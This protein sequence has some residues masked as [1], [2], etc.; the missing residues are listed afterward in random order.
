MPNATSLERTKIPATLRWV[1]VLLALSAFINYIDR[2]NLGIAGPILKAELSVSGSQLGI[3]FSAFFLTYAFLQPVVGWLV[4]RF[5]VNW[6][7]AFGFLLWSL[8]TALTGLAH[9]FGVLLSLR[10]LLGVGESVAYPSYSKIIATRL[11]EEHRGFANACVTGGQTLGPAFG[12]FAGGMLMARFG[13]RPFFIGLGV[14]AMIWLIP[15]IALIPRG[16]EV[17]S[18]TTGVP[19]LLE[20]LVLR[21]AW[22][23]CLGLFCSNY[24]NYFLITW[25]PSYLVRERQFSLEKAASVIAIGYLLA[26]G[27]A[28]LAGWLSDLWI[29]SGGTPTRVRKT[30]VAGSIAISGVCLGLSATGSAAFCALMVVGGIVFWAVSGSNLWAITQTLAGAKAAGRWTGFQNFVGN[31]AGIVVPA[32]TGFTLDRTGHF[33]WALAIL[34]GLALFGA[35]C[36]VFLIGRVEPVVWRKKEQALATAQWRWTLGEGRNQ[37]KL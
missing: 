26:S 4:D 5:N 23:T 21:S 6:V 17:P 14:G 36:W 32:I 16:A 18:R 2:A 20:F 30:I 28:T 25:L 34:T 29:Q 13:W 35:L 37:R 8:A 3:L 15:W 27:C 33:Y 7:F 31:L 10:L 1:L 22:G 12:M 11:P 24:V 19:N 9:L